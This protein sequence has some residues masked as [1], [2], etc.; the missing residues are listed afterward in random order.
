[1]PLP[2]RLWYQI[3]LN[4]RCTWLHGDPRGFR[5]TNKRITSNGDYRHPPPQGEHA[6]LHR[7]HQKRSTAP[8][9]IPRQLFP[10]IGHKL[11]EKIHAQGHRLLVVS[12]DAVHVHLLVELPRERK[13]I[14]H[15]VGLWKQAA[16]HA[17][18]H[19][20]PGRLWAEDCDPEPM[21]DQAHQRNTFY[22]IL[23]HAQHGAWTW[24][25]DQE[26]EAPEG[27]SG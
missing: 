20:M 2:G 3:I 9:R 22:Y 13:R 23:K 10:H 21:N 4:T 26:G 18:R 25:F 12:V 6:D 7:Y 14:K 15:L 24:H 16:S 1:M 11:I 27:K 8:V 5:S 19:E 17:V